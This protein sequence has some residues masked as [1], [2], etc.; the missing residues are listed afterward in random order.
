MPLLRADTL[1][2][3]SDE[4]VVRVRQKVRQ[5]ATE[6]DFSLVEQTKVVT[7]A[8]E[9]ARNTLIHG[10]GGEAILEIHAEG[11]RRKGLRLIFQ[12]NGPGIP[13]IERAMTDGYTTGDGLGLGL[14]G[15]R[16]LSNDFDIRS[17]VGA[18]TRV[19]ITRWK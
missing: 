11:T 3:R 13:D 16:R 8:S 2:V 19:T 9:L 14:S 7:A 12:D 17:E 10:G 4:D 5:W 18:G 15:A 6:L 1:P